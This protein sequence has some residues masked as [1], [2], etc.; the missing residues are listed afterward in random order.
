[1]TTSLATLRTKVRRNIRETT[2]DRWTADD[3]DSFI[4]EAIIFTQ[5]EIEKANESFFLREA[6]VTASANS[7]KVSYPSNVFAQKLRSVF[8]YENSTSPTGVP[9]RVPPGQMEWIL[10]NTDSSGR[11]RNYATLQNYLMWAPLLQYDSC[12]KFVYSMRE[13][14]LTASGDNLTAITDDHADIVAR[15]AAI[16]ALEQVNAPLGSRWDILERRLQ[17]MYHDVQGSDP[18][19]IP[20]VSIDD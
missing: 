12:F 5:S 13:P 4:N 20:Q 19:T 17:Q 18:M 16:L 9:Y 2:A 1:M 10:Q 7:W 14:S 6:T 3:I 11:P 15:Y 8:Y